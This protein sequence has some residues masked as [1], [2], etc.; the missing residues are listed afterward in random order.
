M[1]I[2]KIKIFIG[3]PYI[4]NLEYYSEFYTCMLDDR[5]KTNYSI[6]IR[7]CI[8]FI[9]IK[10]VGSIENNKRLVRWVPFGSLYKTKQ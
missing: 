7:F 6:I 8:A 3:K 1:K 9:I 2:S 4:C 10:R 5:K